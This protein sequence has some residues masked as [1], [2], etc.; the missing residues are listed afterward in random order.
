MRW[1]QKDLNLRPRPRGVHLITGE[2]TAQLPELA[3]FSV[4][5][6]HL[7]L[8]HTSASLALNENA[9][10]DVRRDLEAFLNRL[11]PDESPYFRHRLEG[12]D[13]MPAHVKAVLIGPG[14]WIPVRDGRLYL[15]TWQGI[16]LCEHRDRAGAR[17]VTATLFGQSEEQGP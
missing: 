8:R 1:V 12:P 10:P 9:D 17:S 14:L 6:L 4:G 16:Y 15:G 5:M 7:F 3:W 11:V 13:D 2:I